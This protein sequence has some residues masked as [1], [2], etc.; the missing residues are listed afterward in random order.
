M[1]KVKR[2]PG[3]NHPVTGEKLLQ[4]EKTA[5][6]T[7]PPHEDKRKEELHKEG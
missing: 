2:S 1:M 6:N 3:V 7:A 5:K 4:A